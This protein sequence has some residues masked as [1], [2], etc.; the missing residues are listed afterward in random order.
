MIS[1]DS[2]LQQIIHRVQETQQLCFAHPSVSTLSCS[3]TSQSP[4]QPIAAVSLPDP[5]PIQPAL[6]SAGALPEVALTMEQ[7]YQK[8]AADLRAL[9][10]SA[11]TFI[12]SN[13]AQYP[14][15]F[16]YV[17]EQK[18]LPAFTELYLRQLSTWR[19]DCVELFLK[20]SSRSNNEHASSSA[21]KFNNVRLISY[22]SLV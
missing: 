9:Y 20:H 15:K 4:R 6:L 13:Q 19:Q 17:S 18:I 10:H 7:A 3:Y 5:L 2:I 12:C 11:M 14:S 1:V 8:R 22:L 16:R 21:P